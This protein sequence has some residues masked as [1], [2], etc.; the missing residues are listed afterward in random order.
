MRRLR[1]LLLLLLAPVVHGAFER[2]QL[3]IEREVKS[4]IEDVMSK[5][6]PPQSYLVNVKV[7]M[8]ENPQS[9][10]VRTRRSGSNNPF[11]NDNRFILPGVPVKRELNNRQETTT[12]ETL[13]D[14]PTAVVKRMLINIL[15]ATDVSA[16]KI[17]GI[18]DIVTS[19]TPF[20][21]L[22]GDEID[23]Q[24]SP[25]LKSSR[26]SSSASSTSSAPSAA[27]SSEPVDDEPS[28]FLHRVNWPLVAILG[29][30]LVAFALFLVFL[31][32]PVRGFLNRLL[33]V[34]PR[35]GEQ[36]AYTVSNSPVKTTGG[37]SVNG[38]ASLNGR[39]SGNG[40]G[41]KADDV[42]MPFRFIHEEHLPKLPILLK[43]M[44][45]NQ[46][47]VVLAYLP[48]EWASRILNELD[49][50]AQTSVMQ[51]LSTARQVPSEMVKEVE[52]QVKD[53]LPYLVGGSDWLQSV[54][55]FTEPETQ[56]ALLG[57]LNKQAPELAQSLRRKSFFYEDLAVV[58][59]SALRLLVQ[60][61]GYSV[62]ATALKPEK[63]EWRQSLMAK[64]PTATREILT[65]ELDV[66]AADTVSV[67][68]ARSRIVAAGRRLL[69]E[70]KIALPE[71]A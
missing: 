56:K 9:S 64:L 23:I 47:A 44:P 26:P 40:N 6:L 14:A 11:L 53:K 69:G 65:Q 70:G 5:T 7:E 50:A 27:R 71:K 51:Q 63:A 16:E 21:P 24:T 15:V 31:F 18:Q 33:S 38:S 54:Y 13:M 32:G 45:A 37:V 68:D 62:M 29:L 49:V 10:T 34:L 39:Y 55:Q 3:A 41:P 22:R 58:A 4:R 36:A 52:Q 20:N 8:E 28:G 57:T 46:S 19:N 30:G 60:E 25:M 48:P 1:I 2:E 61:T 12:D 66:A 43:Q 67:A 59:P 35:V 42:N 17:R